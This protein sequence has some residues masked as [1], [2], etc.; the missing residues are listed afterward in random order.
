VCKH[1]VDHWGVCVQAV[2]GDIEA[3]RAARRFACTGMR[4][5]MHKPAVDKTARSLHE[6]AEVK[7]LLAERQQVNARMV[8][9]EWK[10]CES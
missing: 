3:V 8:Y 4:L 7:V 9:G 6:A 10:S 5:Q 1:D 2:Y